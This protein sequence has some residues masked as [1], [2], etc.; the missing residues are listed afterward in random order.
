MKDGIEMETDWL[1]GRARITPNRTAAKDSDTNV[2]W[3]FKQL[4]TRAINLASHL[5]SNG[6]KKGDRVTLISPNHISFLDFLFACTKIGAIFVPINWRL[7]NHEIE[8]ILEDCS[9]K[10]M[11]YTND[12]V[13][14]KYNSIHGKI[15][16]ESTDY[17]LIL[18]QANVHK[19]F[20]TIY[21]EDPACILYTSGS[22]GKPKGVLISHRTL[23][24]NAFNTILSW[25]IK[26]SDITLTCT[27][28]FHTAGLFALT[29]PILMMGGKVII[30]RKFEAEKAIH[31]INQEKC[32]HIFMVPTM[33]H[34]MVQ[35]PIFSET[36]FPY[37]NIFISG[38]SPCPRNIY[39]AFEKR[40]IHFKEAYGMTEAGPNNFYI[41]PVTA[42][43]KIGSV[44]QPMIF[45]DVTI[46]KE[47]GKTADIDEIGEV[48]IS[49]KHLFES[50]WNNQAETDKV[51]VDGQFFT[52]DL[53]K[54]DKDGYFYIVGRKKELI[55]SGG[56]NI[57]PLEIEHVLHDHPAVNENAV[58][59]IPDE[60]WGEIVVAVIS[61]K[62][63]YSIHENELKNYCRKMLAGYKIPRKIYFIEKLPKN[64]A[65]K[66]DK[67]KI[68]ELCRDLDSL[69][70]S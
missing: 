27:P 34:L 33:Y 13:D 63:S 14:L 16:I 19:P 40:G 41:D 42:L 54:R 66:I 12:K 18:N 4:N 53:G 30:L 70:V 61:L 50:Y 31:L 44:G 59:G 21:E 51:L 47:Q 22:T 11:A 60:K 10:F 65:G 26:D 6:I 64:A 23:L 36:N 8:K 45:N 1:E 3:T 38:G 35:S 69:H 15:C 5:I 48:V 2:C 52:G 20:G 57:Y 49:G 43:K 24:S 7:S 46:I 68:T 29:L 9:P 32:T 25:N 56:E 58:V 55:I 39:K 28:M 37:M 17:D 67:K 62:P